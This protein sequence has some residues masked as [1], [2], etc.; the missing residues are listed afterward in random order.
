MLA[1]FAVEGFVM[2]SILVYMVPLMTALEL[3]SAA[4]LVTTLFGP[5]Q[6]A[7]RLINMLFGLKLAQTWL[8]VI[9]AT[10]LPLSLAV[11][12]A[13][14]PWVPGAIAFV[15]LFGM[16]SGLSSIIGGTLPLELF[17]QRGYGA[18]LGWVAAARQFSSAL[19]PFALAMAMAKVGIALSLWLTASVGALGILAFSAIALIKRRCERAV[20]LKCPERVPM[21]K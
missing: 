6:V 17:G 3:G 5:A 21:P 13:T 2:S 18:R 10:L 14:I 19:A 15:I 1:G 12:L 16:A 8:A 11:L 4:V 7:S 20:M 9:G